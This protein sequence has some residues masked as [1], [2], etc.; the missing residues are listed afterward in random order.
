M[1]TATAL[2][3]LDAPDFAPGPAPRDLEEFFGIP[4]SPPENLDANI[5]EKRKYWKKKQQ[6]ARS[7]EFENHAGAVLQAIAEAED[8][9]KR[10]SA[11]TGG[12]GTGFEA[13]VVD[14]APASIDDVWRELERLL[15]R[16][17]YADALD[18]VRQYEE[19]SR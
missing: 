12:G 9:L 19:R 7:E 10:G 1:A 17:R 11:A 15:F 8:A 16:G 5:R 18:R 6:K 3:W 13:E 4:P 2:A 14:R